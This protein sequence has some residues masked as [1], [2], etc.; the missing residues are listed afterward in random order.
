MLH[1]KIFKAKD[2]IK[3]AVF[4]ICAIQKQFKIFWALPRQKDK[5]SA[6]MPANI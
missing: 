2:S 1:Q 3:Y 4:F 6:A 5:P